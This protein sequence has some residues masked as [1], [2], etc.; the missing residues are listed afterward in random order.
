ML[1]HA[2]GHQVIERIG[3]PALRERLEA[4]LLARLPAGERVRENA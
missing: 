2:F 4:A 3:I 1:T